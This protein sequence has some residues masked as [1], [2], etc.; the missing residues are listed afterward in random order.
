MTR[1]LSPAQR[2][3]LE[4]L[5][6]IVDSTTYLA[7]GVAIALR[8]HHRQSRDL[9]LFSPSIDP[10]AQAESIAFTQRDVRILSQSEGTLYLEVQGVPAS[11]I[12]Y[13]YP[14]LLP[15]EHLPGIPIPLASLED[16]MCMKL[17]ALAGRGAARDFWDLHEILTQAKITLAAA[18]GTFARKYASHDIGHLVKSLVYFADAD[19]A[20]LP[21]GLAAEHWQRIKNVVEH[22]VSAL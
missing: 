17:A 1:D 10:V 21:E 12:R 9:D 14:L 20:P 2:D 22:W 11:W 15:V 4:R 7:G 5:A 19:A 13:R 3:A 6:Q 16:L 8:L 18:L